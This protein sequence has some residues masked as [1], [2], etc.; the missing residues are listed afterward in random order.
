MRSVLISVDFIYKKDGSLHPTELNTSTK[1]DLSLGD[2]TKENFVSEVSEFFDH[3]SL[4]LFMIDNNLSKI[5]TISAGGDDTIFRVFCEYY[6]YDFESILVGFGQRTVPY[7]EDDDSTLILRI[8]YDTYAL[9]DDLYARDNYEFHNLIKGES[10]ANP[11]TFVENGFDTIKEFEQSQDGVIPNY[12]IKSR[13]PGFIA[14]YYPKGYRLENVNELENLKKSLGSDEF[15]T[16]FEFNSSLSLEDNRTHHLRTMSIIYGPS[17]DVLNLIHYKAINSVST[18]NDLLV[19]EN[20]VDSNKELDKLFLSKYYP[21]WYS[22]N[23]L[24]YH[25]D[26]SDKILKPDGS[27]VSFVDLQIEEEIQNIFYESP[28]E[29]GELQDYDKINNFILGTSSVKSKTSITGGIFVN[30]TAT[31]EIHGTFSW[32]DGIGNTY[33]IRKPNQSE[34]EVSWLKGG[35]IEIGDEV[36]IYDRNV[37]STISFLVKDISFEIKEKDLY[38]ISISPMPQFMVQLNESNSNLFLVQHN[39]CDSRAGR[40]TAASPLSNCS[41]PTC[42]DCG[43]NSP[44]C[45]NCGGASTVFC[46]NPV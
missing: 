30:I 45:Q 33:L 9:I 22:K 36:L 44:N 4:D 25:S 19:Y 2:L 14:T 17:L 38:M 35:D 34:K 1:Y 42:I 43:K 23:G 29:D 3:E 7:V 12:V 31:N 28:L 32:H 11:V 10:F 20:E 46:N 26:S 37:N 40:C 8:A 39:A 18:Q 24:N 15:I 41:Q 5:T 21:T 13:T 27:L 16:R 6:S